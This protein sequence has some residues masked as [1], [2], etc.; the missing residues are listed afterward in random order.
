[1]IEGNVVVRVAKNPLDAIRTTHK[2]T[3]HG[4]IISRSG[5]YFPDCWRLLA[6]L[7]PCMPFSP[8]AFI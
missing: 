2:K 8:V 3:A 7:G 4:R 1:M 6:I 5:L